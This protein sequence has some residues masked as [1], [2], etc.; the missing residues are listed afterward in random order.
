MIGLSCSSSLGLELSFSSS[1][2]LTTSLVAFECFSF[3][4]AVA[5]VNT[6]VNVAGGTVQGVDLTVIA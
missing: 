6:A 5:D 4:T 3:S 2:R 1:T